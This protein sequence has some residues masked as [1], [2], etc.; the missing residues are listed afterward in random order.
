MRRRLWR[1]SDDRRRGNI[2]TIS[3]FGGKALKSGRR[4]GGR[5]VAAEYIRRGRTP[6]W[7]G[8]DDIIGGKKLASFF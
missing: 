8:K 4:K 3:V 2:E 6:R 7:R 1:K 5:D